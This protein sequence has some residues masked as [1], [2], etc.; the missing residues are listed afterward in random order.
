MPS[1]MSS[2]C[3]RTAPIHGQRD[4]QRKGPHQHPDPGQ[5]ALGLELRPQTSP[6][7]VALLCQ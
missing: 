1:P 6:A 7:L 2:L 5:E 3:S 4:L